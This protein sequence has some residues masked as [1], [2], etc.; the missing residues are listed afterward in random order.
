MSKVIPLVDVIYMTRNQKE[1][2][3]E[4]DPQEIKNKLTVTNFSTAKEKCIILYLGMK[5]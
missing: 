5:N 3:N 4:K 2:H 1:R